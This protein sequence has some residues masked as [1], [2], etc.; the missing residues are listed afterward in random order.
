MG[1]QG[2]VTKTDN[3]QPIGSF[4]VLESMGVFQDQAAID[5]YVDARGQKIQPNAQPGDLQYRDTDG[6]GVINDL[7]R[8]YAGSYQ[9]RLYY[10]IN[11]G[12]N[13]KSVDLSLDFYGNSGNKIYNGRR[14][15][16]TR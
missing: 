16:A 6:N 15:S 13:Y 1:Q 3:G 5:A 9:P 12:A 11:L 14:P 4:F 7:D 10:G 8:I 2:N